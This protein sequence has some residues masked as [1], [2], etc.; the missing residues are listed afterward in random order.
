[1]TL[2]RGLP[3]ARAPVFTLAARRPSASSA[4]FLR[5]AV[6]ELTLKRAL[7]P[8]HVSLETLMIVFRPPNPDHGIKKDIRSSDGGGETPR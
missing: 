3:E 7:E 1:M 6:G 2:V 5:V 4:L 8:E